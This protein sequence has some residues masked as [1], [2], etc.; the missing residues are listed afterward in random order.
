[1]RVENHNLLNADGSSSGCQQNSK[2]LSAVNVREGHH[3]TTHRSVGSPESPIDHS[4]AVLEIKTGNETQMRKWPCNI[5][6]SGGS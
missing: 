2:E 4:S 5:H 1:M 3:R 6:K